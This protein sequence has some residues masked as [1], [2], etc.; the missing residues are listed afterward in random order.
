MLGG[1]VMIEFVLGF[2]AGIAVAVCG[3]A[4]AL[5]SWRK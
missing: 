4:L 3:L 2:F 1:V 5:K